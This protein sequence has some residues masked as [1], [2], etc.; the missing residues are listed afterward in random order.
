MHSKETW[1]FIEKSDQVENLIYKT[2]ILCLFTTCCIKWANQQ[3]YLGTLG[4]FRSAWASAQFDQ[5]SLL[6]WR[7][8][9][10]LATHKT[11]ME[12]WSDWAN[13]QADLSLRWAHR[14]LCRD[15]L[16][17]TQIVHISCFCFQLLELFDSEDPRERDFLKTVLHRIY[18]KF[19]GLRAFIRKQINNIFLK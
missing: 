17:L 7:R 15:F 18:G 14:L 12:D 13:A 2:N 1:T 16:A 3:N 5:S 9:V 6:A 19:L 4:R 11:H 10:S 8:F